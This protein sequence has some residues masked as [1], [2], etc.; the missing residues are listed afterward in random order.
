MRKECIRAVRLYLFILCLAF[1]VQGQ[2]SDRELGFASYQTGDYAAAV[3]HFKKA[4]AD[5]ANDSG[6]WLYLGFANLHLKKGKE[7]SRAFE[8][9]RKSRP[10]DPSA[11]KFTDENFRI[12]KKPQPKGNDEL[13]QK[14]NEARA[15]VHVELRSDG[16]I[17]MVYIVQNSAI[18]WERELRNAV[19]GIRFDPAKKNGVPVTTIAAFEFSWTT[20]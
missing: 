14:Y 3:E 2:D 13:R 5:D 15:K 8:A 6:S 11:L 4:V 20:F 12:T 1:G 9:Q 18:E 16:T 17:G 19:R 10:S 7:A